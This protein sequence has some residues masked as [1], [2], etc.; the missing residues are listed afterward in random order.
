VASYHGRKHELLA[1]VAAG[2][3]PEARRALAE[4]RYADLFGLL[5]K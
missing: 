2:G 3:F 1:E 4:G 5:P